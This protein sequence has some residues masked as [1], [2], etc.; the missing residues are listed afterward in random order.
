MGRRNPGRTTQGWGQ[1]GIRLGVLA[2]RKLVCLK[3]REVCDLH[4]MTGENV[5]FLKP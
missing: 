5:P 3:G 4:E 2:W 1:E